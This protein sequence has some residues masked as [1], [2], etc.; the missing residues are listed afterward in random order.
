MISFTI[1][2]CSDEHEL[3]IHADSPEPRTDT[4]LSK[5]LYY[6]PLRSK[7]L[8][9]PTGTQLSIVKALPTNSRLLR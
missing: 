8:K 4:S 9:L 5:E 2:N 6:L 3:S 7:E 1:I